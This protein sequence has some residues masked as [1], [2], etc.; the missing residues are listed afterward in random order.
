MASVPGKKFMEETIEKILLEQ[1][2]DVR[3]ESNLPFEEKI[4]ILVRMQE[5]TAGMRPDLDWTVWAIP[6]S[7]F[8]VDK[9]DGK[10]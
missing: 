3:R 1:S 10:T 8:P 7:Q 6:Q 4:R 9:I 5:R 2:E